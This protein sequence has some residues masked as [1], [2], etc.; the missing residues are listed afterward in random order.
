[1]EF[2][3]GSDYGGCY[4]TISAWQ[5]LPGRQLHC[6]LYQLRRHEIAETRNAMF[7][8]ISYKPTYNIAYDALT[9]VYVVQLLPY[10]VRAKVFLSF[11]FSIAAPSSLV[12]SSTL[13]ALK[14]R[15]GGIFPSM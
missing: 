12:P 6:V 15:I 8:I 3:H 4:A 2:R 7:V 10:C 5:E 1:M 9:Y 13:S 11:S 14:T